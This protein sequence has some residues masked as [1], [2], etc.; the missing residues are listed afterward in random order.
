MNNSLEYDTYNIHL[1]RKVPNINQNLNDLS[2]IEVHNNY[3]YR[4]FSKS[5][6]L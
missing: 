1:I 2:L 4:M 5:M 6:T 3:F